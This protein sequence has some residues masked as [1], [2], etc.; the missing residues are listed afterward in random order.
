MRRDPIH[1]FAATVVFKTLS[2]A[3][4]YRLLFPEVVLCGTDIDAVSTQSEVRQLVK[5]SG[6]EPWVS[7]RP[8]EFGT[9]G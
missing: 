5:L 1:P 2:Q 8:K 9:V 3:R 4:S 6:R 7:G